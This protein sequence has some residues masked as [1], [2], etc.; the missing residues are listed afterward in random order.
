MRTM[1]KVTC[2]KCRKI[3]THEEDGICIICKMDAKPVTSDFSDF[4]AYMF[5][6]GNKRHAK[7]V[8]PFSMHYQGD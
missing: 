5:T 2:I 1:E 6:K 4:P 7:G 3:S 8:S